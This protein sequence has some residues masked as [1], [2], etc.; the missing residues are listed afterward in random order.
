MRRVPTMEVTLSSSRHPSHL[1]AALIALFVTFLWSSS[2]VLIRWGLDD[3][4]LEPITFAALRY[5]MAAGI[6]ILWVLGR[7]P[8]RQSVR[9]LDR[10]TLYLIAILGVVFYALNQ[11]AQFVAIDSQPAATT[12]LVFSW[13]PLFVAL[14]GGW[15]IGEPP[16]RRQVLGTLLVGAGAW[17]YFSG[18]LGATTVGLAAAL[19]GLGANV[20]S[21]LLGRRVNRSG[22]VAPVV[23]TALSM[24]I[25]AGILIAT[26]IAVEGIPAITWRA[27][28]II[29]WLAI[30]NTAFAFTLWNL[31]LRRLA[32]L[33]SA[34]INNTMLIQIAVL[35]WIFLNE[36][37]GVGEVA[38]IVLVS[39]GVLMT[40]TGLLR[41]RGPAAPPTGAEPRSDS[42]ASR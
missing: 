36:S 28:L 38:G 17:I 7:R 4:A 25:G 5:G 1:R 20:A 35:A 29:S 34:A 2:W 10:S 6:L 24:A 27:G 18:D 23:V 14:L 11:G 8:L 33:E 40:Q 42:R 41:G 37:L 22:D 16:N 32:A 26:G 15:S 21:A 39:A 19:V 12:S 31:S 30:V 9:G 3:E 13:T